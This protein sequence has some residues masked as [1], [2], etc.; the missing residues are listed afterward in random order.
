M[1]FSNENQLLMTVDGKSCIERKNL[2]KSLV[3]SGS[4]S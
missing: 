2:P 3:H 4:P 1:K